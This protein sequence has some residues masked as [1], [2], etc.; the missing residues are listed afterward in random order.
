MAF[1][2]SMAKFKALAV[3]L[4]FFPL[5]LG[6]SVRPRGASALGDVFSRCA[7]SVRRGCPWLVHFRRV[8]AL[9]R[10]M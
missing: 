1:V 10:S 5:S 2:R 3:A 9:G 6:D 4:V 7:R 8:F